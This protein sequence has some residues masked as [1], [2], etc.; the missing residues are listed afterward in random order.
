MRVRTRH[1]VGLLLGLALIIAVFRV[2]P[3][4]RFAPRP[5]GP[6][7]A[8]VVRGAIHVH[9]PADPR[10]FHRLVSAARRRHL[11]FIIFSAADGLDA[12]RD[13]REGYY[14]V[15]GAG[16]D[17]GRPLLVLIGAEISTDRGNLLVVGG[18]P[19]RP[20][21]LTRRAD[22]VIAA[23]TQLGAVTLALG[24]CDRPGPPGTRVSP[25]TPDPPA[26]LASVEAISLAA[27]LS[28][29]RYLDL[30]VAGAVAPVD[31]AGALASVT[32]TWH[33]DGGLPAPLHWAGAAA[34]TGGVGLSAG[35]SW[36]DGPE[37]LGQ[38]LDWVTT[39][40]RLDARPGRRRETF[41][42][43]RAALITALAAGRSLAAVEAWGDPAA[44]S[45]RRMG[46]RMD[47]RIQ[48]ETDSWIVLRR[49][50]AIVVS[51]PGPG[52]SA[53]I[54]AD[55]PWRAEFYR[56][57]DAVGLPGS[58]WVLWVVAGEAFAREASG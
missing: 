45:L 31:L 41:D 57:R 16:Q 33:P 20:L 35:K 28:S 39:W 11:D 30:A 25:A 38:A 50:G 53:P 6:V 29:N 46:D 55:G 5:P 58:G 34:P 43:D 17:G 48:G 12:A 18:D 24:P 9:L 22:R 42:T 26:N 47:A 49:D 8:L 1:A 2:V 4:V 23:A 13:G 27:T 19:R 40:L 36:G 14:T 15:R 10:A 7:P 52:V 21:P 44:Q 54:A 56:R 32:P 3:Y 51:G 37:T